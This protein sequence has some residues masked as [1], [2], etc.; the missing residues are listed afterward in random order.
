VGL[1]RS[2]IAARIVEAIAAHTGIPADETDPEAAFADFGIAS[3]DVMVLLGDLQA[4]VGRELSPQIFWD[5]VSI[6]ALSEYLASAEAP[7]SASASASASQNAAAAQNT[8]AADVTDGSLSAPIAVI[9]FACRFPGAANAQELW[10]L[11]DE[12]IDAISDRSPAGRPVAMRRPHGLLRDISGFDAPFFSISAAEAAYLDPQQRLLLE[13]A[14]EA[15]EDAAVAPASLAGTRTGVFVGIIGS[16]YG[17]LQVARYSDEPSRYVASGQALSIAANRLSYFLDLRGPSFAVDTACSSSLVS[18][19]QACRS[20][21]LGESTTAI[22]GGVNLILDPDVT[23][24]FTQAGMMAADGRCKTFD[25]S[26]D[27][28]VRSEGC[29]LMVLKPLSAAVRDGDRVHGVILGSAVNQDGRSNGLTAPSGPAQQAVIADALR[30]AGI[31]AADVDYV[32]AHGTGTRLGDPIETNAL[33]AVIGAGRTTADPVILGSIKTNIGHTEGAAGAAGLIKVLLMLQ[34]AKIPASLHLRELNPE[35]GADAPFTIPGRSVAWNRRNGP[36]T[37]G[38]SSFGFGGTNAHVILRELPPGPLVPSGP[39]FRSRH[40]LT[41]AARTKTALPVLAGRYATYLRQNPQVPIEDVCHTAN[42]GRSPLAHRLGLAVAGREEAIARLEEFAAGT[43]AAGTHRSGTPAV[44]DSRLTFLFSG[45]GAQYKDMGRQLMVS[46]ALLRTTILE[47]DRIIR[48]LLRR[49]L[50]SIMFPAPD[51]CELI[52]QTRYTQPALFALEYALA[53]LWQS[54]GVRPDYVVGHSVGALAAACVAGVFSLDDGLRLAVERGRVMQECADEGAMIAVFTD[55]ADARETVTALRDNRMVGIAAVNGSQNI[56]I[57]G[58]VEAI[59]LLRREFQARKI[60]V[61]DLPG[62]L[63]F[64][65]PMMLRARDAFAAVAESV[66]YRSPQIPM[67]SDLDGSLFDAQNPPGAEYWIRHLTETVRYADAVRVL[68]ALGSDRFVEVG[69]QQVLCK[70]GSREIGAG[71]WVPSLRR[72]VEDWAVLADSVAQLFAAG[73]VIDWRA[74]HGDRPRPRAAHP[75]LPTYPFERQAHWLPDPA[76]PADLAAVPAGASAGGPESARQAAPVAALARVPVPVPTAAAAAGQ[77]S[78]TPA[79]RFLEV[80][81]RVMRQAFELLRGNAPRPENVRPVAL[82]PLASDGAPATVNHSVALRPLTAPRPPAAPQSP[83][84][85]KPPAAQG[86][87]RADN[88]GEAFPLSPMQQEIWLLAQMKPEYSRA[89]NESVLLD[90]FGQLA[91]ELF[92][93][94][95]AHVMGRHGALR[96]AFARSGRTQ[97]I[98]D[99]EIPV[100]L[101]DFSGDTQE[102]AERVTRWLCAQGDEAFD[103]AAGRVAQCALLRLAPEHHQIYIAAH[104]SVIDGYSF[105]V[106]VEEILQAYEQLRNGEPISL[107]PAPVYRDFVQKRLARAA[108]P[109]GSA[110][111]AYWIEQFAAG[112]PVLK[113]PTD[114]P[115]SPHSRQLGGLVEEP[116]DQ[117]VARRIPAVARALGVTEFTLLLAA[118]ARLLHQ[119][120]GME[121]VVIGVPLT[122]RDTEEANRLVGNCITVIPVRSELEPGLTVRDYV[123]KIQ[124]T[125]L[126]AYQHPGFHPMELHDQLGIGAASDTKIYGSFFNLDRVNQSLPGREISI[127]TQHPPVRFAKTD[128]SLDVLSNDGGFMLAA[129]YDAELFSEPTIRRLTSL[130]GNLVRQLLESDPNLGFEQLS[131]MRGEA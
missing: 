27:G 53:R 102:T 12:G 64:H 21:R 131:V 103:L 97:R 84:A 40:V 108:G 118:Y 122:L 96:T 29:A 120:S 14:W 57:S 74:F 110:D 100:P 79:R 5:H 130:Y 32:E 37:A 81:E 95:A 7:A 10:Q 22:A 3:R 128:F 38:V 42:V 49:S 94:A 129:A 112:F 125:L 23:E 26:A 58:P 11:L 82:K 20:L 33:A 116:V 73:Q 127:K 55:E 44:A 61:V 126:D 8:D 114:R 59:G 65:S 50:L 19:H 90:I 71:L 86:S 16:D 72:A 1:N 60:G 66:E 78:A 87:A 62:K 111:R 43:T 109:E 9:G 101:I 105:A 117:E 46:N 93:S 69:P 89:Y 52:D 2:E 83:T 124:R 115:R 56:T 113:L 34:H 123:R 91:A 47:C 68:A 77:T 67:V 107:P 4:M 88:S 36:R 119:V 106:L 54:F 80:H 75:P 28:Y 31:P 6:R 13:V 18:V 41:V 98:I 25:A 92:C 15:L 104:H 76:D 45:Q 85:S 99:T 51:E 121:Q 70:A 24:I 48:P 35:I 30:D 17:R 63:A 39:D